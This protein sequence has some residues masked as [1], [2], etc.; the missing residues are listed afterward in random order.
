MRRVVQSGAAR[1]DLVDIVYYDLQK[2]TPR[3]AHRFRKQAE[4]TFQ[5]L[6]ATP[7]IGTRYEHEH[8]ALADLPYFP[9]S[10]FRNYLVFY[11]PLP[12]GIAVA[13]VLHGARDIRRILAEDFGAEGGVDDDANE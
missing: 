13:R 12:D 2:G 1:R 7:G 3:T 10:R 11:R 5:R 9:F 6:A 8:P 4:A